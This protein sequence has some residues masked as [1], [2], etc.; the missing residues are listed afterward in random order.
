MP[1][2]ASPFWKRLIRLPSA[3][4]RQCTPLTSREAPAGTTA[5]GA[6]AVAGAGMPAT[7]TTAGA[8]A[9]TAGA[10]DLTTGSVA[11]GFVPVAPCDGAATGLNTG[12][13][14]DVAAWLPCAIA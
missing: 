13:A 10:A 9:A 11:G 8:V 4:Q 7:G 6:L 2:I 3:G 5:G 1:G 14:A 12:A